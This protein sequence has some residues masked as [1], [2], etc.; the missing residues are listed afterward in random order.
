M[1][2]SSEVVKTPKQVRKIEQQAAVY[3]ERLR[4]PVGR[5]PVLEWLT[6]MAAAAALVT[7]Y[8]GGGELV[9]QGLLR[10]N[11]VVNG[12]REIANMVAS[13]PGMILEIGAIA[14]TA[15]LGGLAISELKKGR[16]ALMEEDRRD[17]RS[18]ILGNG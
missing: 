8:N 11:E 4:N 13:A 15:F 5:S 10:V 17:K 6:G 9:R 16:I 2:E 1:D 3:E 12:G 14:G 18:R 7:E